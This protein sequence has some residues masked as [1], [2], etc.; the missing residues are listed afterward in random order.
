MTERATSRRRWRIGELADATGLTVRTLRH[1][2][3]IGLL[4]PDARTAGRQRLYDEDDLRRLYRIRALRDLGLSLTDIARVLE[5]DRAGLADVLRAHRARVGVE[6]ERLSRLRTLLDHA[7]ARAE[8]DV[9]ADEVLATIEAMSRVV[10]RGDAR[11]GKGN[12]SMDAEAW[13]RTLG[14]ALRA[15][16]EAREDPSA[17]RPRALASAALARMVEFAGGDRATLE[18]LAHLRR[19][20]PPEDLAGWSPALM[21]YLDQALTHLQKTECEPC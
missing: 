8:H 4:A 10:R 15:C 18:A 20:A 2:E 5:D 17:P 7:C 16:M 14:D 13:W 1:Y 21:R 6:I 3:H 12:E 19:F 9:G 11:Q